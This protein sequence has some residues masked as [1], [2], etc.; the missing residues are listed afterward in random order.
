MAHDHENFEVV[1]PP[2]EET[3]RRRP[4]PPITVTPIP[5]PSN[6]TTRL[7]FDLPDPGFV[8]VSVLDLRGRLVRQLVNGELGRGAHVVHWNGIDAR[9]DGVQSGVYA[10]RIEAL[11]S[12][13]A[14]KI[15]LVK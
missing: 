6:S 9:G 4:R 7:A 10:V 1:C 14:T 5:N 15:V 12:S 13:F 8:T 3:P 11:G 2:A